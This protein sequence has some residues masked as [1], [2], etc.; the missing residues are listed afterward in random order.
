MS[1]PETPEVHL[2]YAGRFAEDTVEVLR[3]DTPIET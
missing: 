1:C 2:K 3:A